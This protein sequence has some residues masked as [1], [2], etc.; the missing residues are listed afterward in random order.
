MPKLRHRCS[1]S[2]QVIKISGRMDDKDVLAASG[3]LG[4]TTGARGDVR[5]IVAESMECRMMPEG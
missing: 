3:N 4:G 1:Q 2:K 5:G